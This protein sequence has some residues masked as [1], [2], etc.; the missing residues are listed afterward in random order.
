MFQPGDVFASVSNGRV[1]WM[2]SDGTVVQTLDTGLGG[3]TT[4]MAFDSL[5]NLYVTNFSAGTVSRFDRSG[6]LLG[7]FGSSYSVA[8]E[9]ILFDTDGNMYVGHADGDQDIRKFDTGGNLI[10]QF[11]VATEARGSDW[12]DLLADQCT[13]FYTSEDYSILRYD[14]CTDTQLPN[15]T[16]LPDRPAYALRLLDSGE[17][18][19]ADDE[20]IHLIGT[21]GQVVRTYDA[22]GEDD[23][24]ALNLDPDGTSF[25]SG[26]ISTGFIYKFDIETGAV[27]VG[28]LPTCGSSC[29]FGLAVFSER[30]D[31]S[32][33]LKLP[34][35]LQAATSKADGTDRINAYFDHKYPLVQPRFG[36][37]EP[38]DPGI[39]D[40]VV[41]YTGEETPDC[42]AQPSTPYCTYYSGHDAYDFSGIGGQTAVLA[43]HAGTASA[44]RWHCSARSSEINVVKITKGRYQTRYLHIHEDAWFTDLLSGAREVTAGERIGTVGNTGFP[45]CSTGAH[46]HFGVYYD[47]NDNGDFESNERVDPYGFNPTLV[48]PWVDSPYSGAMSTWLW[49]FN[50]LSQVNATPSNTFSL[51][52]G[53]VTVDAEP[54]TV[55]GSTLV[56]L[57]AAPTKVTLTHNQ[58]IELGSNFMLSGAAPDGSSLQSFE[59]PVKFTFDYSAEDISYIDP[60]TLQIRWWN[61]LSSNWITLPS[62]ID[63]SLSTISTLS[64]NIGLYSLCATPINPSPIIDNVSPSWLLSSADRQISISGSGFANNPWV[65]IV[66][67]TA[68]EVVTYSATT[69]K[70]N[71]PYDVGPGIYDVRVRNNDGQASVLEDGLTIPFRLHVPLTLRQ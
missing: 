66:G 30:V 22:A 63:N 37:T 39:G 12:V 27:S 45:D 24:F 17:I 70:V 14:V 36:G 57:M 4:G 62:T 43:A 31:S 48:D 61:T 64:T 8:P 10:E 18:L 28:P 59:L 47:E 16:T 11:D 56:A 46:L 50:R 26:G 19:V 23:W 15:F 55:S 38:S 65:E 7:T 60:N 53:N 49:E 51:R 44:E 21:A 69:L 58:C 6:N 33:K 32:F 25:W 20:A 40:I 41:T 54:N 52:S 2:R 67:I 35:E 1:L 5:N 9:S 13:M 42:W 29:L 34:F 3:F 71:V 68:L